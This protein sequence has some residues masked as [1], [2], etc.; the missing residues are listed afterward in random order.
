MYGIVNKLPLNRE[1][2]LLPFTITSSLH[3]SQI[4]TTL[5]RNVHPQNHTYSLLQ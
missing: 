4:D 5:Y 3:S 2:T 1:E